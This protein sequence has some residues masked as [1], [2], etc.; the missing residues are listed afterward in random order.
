MK[1]QSL[2]S[3][4]IKDQ[5]LDNNQGFPQTFAVS[6]QPSV[7]EKAKAHGLSVSEVQKLEQENLSTLQSL[8]PKEIEKLQNQ[9]KDSLSDNLIKM[10]KSGTLYQ[11]KEQQIFQE[12]LQAQLKLDNPL[13]QQYLTEDDLLIQQLQGLYEKNDLGSIKMSIQIINQQI[14]NGMIVQLEKIKT[15]EY[16]IGLIMSKNQTLLMEGLNLLN[17]Y[18]DKFYPKNFSSMYN[19][20]IQLLD[21]ARL[22]KFI[23]QLQYAISINMINTHIYLKLIRQYNIHFKQYCKLLQYPHQTTEELVMICVINKELQKLNLLDYQGFTNFELFFEYIQ[24]F[25]DH[26]LNQIVSQASKHNQD[27]YAQVLIQ[28][29]NNKFNTN[30]P[31]CLKEQIKYLDLRKDL[32]D[33]YVMNFD[34]VLHNYSVNLRLSLINCYDYQTVMIEILQLIQNLRMTSKFI[35]SRDKRAKIMNILF[36]K[37]RVLLKPILKR[38]LYT[39]S[40]QGTDLMYVIYQILDELKIE[41]QEE[42]M[43][44]EYQFL[45]EYS[46]EQLT[47]P[48][49]LEDFDRYERLKLNI[50]YLFLRFMKY[51]IKIEDL[52]KFGIQIIRFLINRIDLDQIVKLFNHNQYVFERLL[53]RFQYDSFNNQIH[54]TALS[55]FAFP[56]IKFEINNLLIEEFQRSQINLDLESYSQ[57]ID[58]LIVNFKNHS[59]RYKYLTLI[60]LL[61]ENDQLKSY[62]QKVEQQLE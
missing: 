35:I 4:R 62:I 2:F 60:D 54:I 56:C 21:D 39:Y 12:D 15:S 61:E 43:E 16:I 3:Q 33:Y 45:N 28:H 59:N 52:G 20:Q 27:Y 14:S 13:V 6:S 25:D 49:L 47:K 57:I 1:K 9:L 53:Q 36:D 44:V 38:K 17:L 19:D 55:L 42:N 7:E 31:Y 8:D 32:D 10:F 34:S 23:I 41:I 5:K 48:Q 50:N 30:Y 29:Y 51:I 40:A 37:L 58:K 22:N 26:I 18:F 46:Q 24:Y 11:K